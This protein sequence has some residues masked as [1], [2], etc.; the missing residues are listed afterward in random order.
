[1]RNTASR[2]LLT[3]LFLLAFTGIAEAK[4]YQPINEIP[5]QV[6]E[7]EEEEGVWQVGLAHQQKVRG[8]AELVNNAELERYLEGIVAR[9]MGDMV[10]AIGLEVDVLVF[11]DPTVNAWAYPNGTVAVQTGLLAAMENEAQLA[12]I[13]GHEVSHYLNRHAFIQIKS[14][15]TQS[16]IGKG[17]GA[18]ATIAVAAKTG[19]VATGL[20]DSGRIWTDLV[21]SG[22]SRKL[23]TAA[24]EQGLQ[25]MIDAGY[26]PEEALPAFE[27]MRIDEDDEINIDKIWSSHPDIDSRKKNLARRIKKAKVEGN[28]A[29]LDGAAYLRAVRLAALANS[30]L[31][32]QNRDF[33]GAIAR[34]EKYT[35]T[36]QEDATGFYLLGEAYRKQD[37]EGDYERRMGAYERALAVDDGMAAAWR[38]LGMAYRQ[39]GMAAQ[40]T[41]ALARYLALKPGAADAPII[42]WYR[43]NPGAASAAQ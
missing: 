38:E 13:L 2:F 28:S 35:G 9:L 20:L 18:L 10:K 14:K 8:S 5:G 42:G 15:Q 3:T 23:E 22:Y 34:L 30:Q 24:D 4:K 7:T 32:V 33:D 21:T 6:P 25:F 17:L 36:L 11:R 39:Q 12:A 19:T 41:D 40:A 16:A 1:M 43:D 37:P 29:G 27:A 31:Q 26:P